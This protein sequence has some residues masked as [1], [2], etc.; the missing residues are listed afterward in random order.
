MAVVDSRGEQ[1]DLAPV[2]AMQVRPLA[3]LKDEPD[4]DGIQQKGGEVR[5]NEDRSTS[6]I[7]STSAIENVSTSVNMSDMSSPSLVGQSRNIKPFGRGSP[8]ANVGNGEK[9]KKKSAK[10][11]YMYIQDGG[12]GGEEDFSFPPPHREDLVVGDHDI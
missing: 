5:I 10:Q 2:I 3:N 6:Q 9:H 4:S 12:G 7:S 11:P 1:E 8:K